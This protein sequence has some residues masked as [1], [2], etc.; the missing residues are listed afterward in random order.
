[1][2]SRMPG[3]YDMQ[4]QFVPGMPANAAA[5]HTATTGYPSQGYDANNPNRMLMQV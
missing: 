1:M 5:Y 2:N 3:V 4:Q